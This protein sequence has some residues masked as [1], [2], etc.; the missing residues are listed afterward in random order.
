MQELKLLDSLKKHHLGPRV[1][2]RSEGQRVKAEI[3]AALRRTRE[4]DVLLV[5][6]SGVEV[7]S[8]SFADEVI[9]IPLSRLV[10][11]EYGEKYIV[12]RIERDDIC[13]D[14]AAALRKRGLSMLRI[15]GATSR[16]C[17]PLGA[18]SVELKGT[19]DVIAKHG[20]VSTGD[21]AKR[22]GLKLQA[23]S[24][25]VVELGR[26]RLIRRDR[27]EGERGLKHKNALAVA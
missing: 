19:L 1:G 15:R 3:D 21:L 14:V 7:M 5:D 24:N 22:L 11:G 13:E 23:C 27:V 20:P 12:A 6:F 10:A 2:T 16:N 8:H 26:Q 17:Q 4:T 25:R 9:A 18:I